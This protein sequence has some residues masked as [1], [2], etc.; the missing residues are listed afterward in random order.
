M[1][2]GN[3]AIFFYKVLILE[4]MGI[5]NY[6]ILLIE[7]PVCKVCVVLQVLNV[8]EEEF[9]E[10][11]HIRIMGRMR[12][13]LL[14]RIINIINRVCDSDSDCLKPGYWTQILVWLCKFGLHSHFPSIWQGL[15]C[16]AVTSKNT[17]TNLFCVFEIST[18]MKSCCPPVSIVL[19]VIYGLVVVVVTMSITIYH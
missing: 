17:S 1:Y 10:Y 16:F 7:T 12:L 6:S 14:H 8:E 18:V 13:S 4:K 3:T 11:E 19:C 5:G 9:S 15:Y 2:G